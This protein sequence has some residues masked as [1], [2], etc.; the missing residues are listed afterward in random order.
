MN[1]RT[2]W[3]DYFT[4]SPSST[5]SNDYGTQ[6]TPSGNVYVSNCL[7]RSITS[8]SSGGGALYCSSSVTLLLV[9]SSSFSSCTTSGQ[10]GGA[11]YFSNTGSGQS[12]LHAVCGYDCYSTYTSSIS[13]GQ[14]SRTNVYNADSSKNYVNCSSIS[15]C[16]NERS[17]S[18]RTIYLYYGKTYCQSTNMSMNKCYRSSAILCD[19]FRN[20]NS[21][22]CLFSYSS[23]VDNIAIDHSCLVLWISS[24]NNEIKSCNILRNTQGTLGTNG[25][26]YTYANLIIEGSCILGNSANNIFYASSSS[27]TITVSNCTV[28]KRTSNYGLTILNTATKSFILALNH[29][30]TQNCY[31]EYD[32]VGAL[33]PNIQS[34]SSSKKQRLY[35]SCERNIYQT[36]L[37]DFISL[38]C[39]FLFSFIHLDVSSDLFY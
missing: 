15:R 24:S 9:E 33:T 23:F 19:C 26:I 38:L 31:S 14:F 17:S 37:R 34:P 30:S 36:Q 25:I 18:Y 6:Q 29:L 35:Y 7:F 28:D 4:G 11:I 39:A 8:G 3:S 13:Y 1:A 22:S 21:V 12:V 16:V 20:S 2:A 32:A 5:L 10:N 27:Y